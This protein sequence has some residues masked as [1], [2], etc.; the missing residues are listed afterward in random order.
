MPTNQ[1][2]VIGA[3]LGE[4]QMRIYHLTLPSPRLFLLRRAAER[5]QMNLPVAL[6]SALFL[7]LLRPIYA[8]PPNIIFI[9]ADD[10]GYADA[11]CYGQQLIKTPNIDRLAE[12]GIRF[13]ECYAGSAVC[14]PSRCVLMTG[15]HTGHTRVRGNFGRYGIQ[16]LGGGDGRVPLFDQD[17]T[18]AEVLRTAD[19]RTGITGKW[20]LG[21][22]RTN[23]TP[24][25]QGFES[26]FGFLNQRRAHNHYPSYL[27]LNEDKFDLTGNANDKQQLYSHDLFTGHA[28][29]F[30]R[31]HQDERFFL[32]VPYTVPHAHFQIPDLGDYEDTD[33]PENARAY[34]AMITRMDSDIGRILDLLDELAIA[35]KTMVFFCSDNGAANRYDGLFDSSGPLRGRKRDIYEGGLRTPM[36]IRWPDRIKAGRSSALPWSFADVLPTLAEAAET[37]SPKG[38]DGVSILP[39]LLGEQQDLSERFLYW[40]FHGGGFQQ[41]SRWRHWKAIRT[42]TNGPLELYNLKNDIGET[43]NVAKVNPEV[44]SRFETFLASARTPSDEWPTKLDDQQQKTQSARARI[45]ES[46]RRS[47]GLIEKSSA[48]YLKHR[49][50]FSCHHQAMPLLALTKAK[51][52]GYDVNEENFQAQVTHTIEHLKRGE[53]NYRKGK[54]QG[55]QVDTAGY[56]LWA[57]AEAEWT[58]DETTSAVVE[59]LLQRDK[60]RDYWRTTSH[61]PPSE[62]S[63]FTATAVALYGLNYF[64][65]ESESGRYEERRQ[66]V[67]EWLAETLPQDTED[68]VFRL[69]SLHFLRELVGEDQDKSKHVEEVIDKTARRLMAEQRPDGGF[70]Q[71]KKMQ[72]DAYATATALAALHEVA[73]VPASSS[74]YERG[75]R[76]LLRQQRQD[77]S[78]HVKSRS[79]P[80]QVYFESGFPHGE[81]QF[82]SISAT[83]WATIALLNGD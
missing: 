57:L 75:V 62:V 7:I 17:V 26:W 78:W 24:N 30:I 48:E 56:A 59:Y 42:K 82:I 40:E 53:T 80:F 50:C 2:T 65:P 55:G 6:C 29:H 14:A 9:M 33:W 61:R 37:D 68:C 66:R 39:T 52:H 74:T 46:I 11:G 25:R 13:T 36:V 31:E 71:T 49:K 21:E 72:S 10:M 16:G 76:Y 1:A 54:G 60:N 28:L 69:F 34:A 81:D 35:Q 79:K 47:I 19:Y 45:Q 32:Y 43:R 3:F 77:G 67:V 51:T 15:L 4:R 44:V 23:G 8:A 83:C 5:G 22:P 70:A 27:W 12:E 41:A 18:I 63:D 58:P 20:G 38:L 73:N 64:C